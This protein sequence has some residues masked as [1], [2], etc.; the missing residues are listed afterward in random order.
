MNTGAIINS[1]VWSFREKETEAYKSYLSYPV[2]ELDMTHT[3]TPT[4]TSHF[5]QGIQVKKNQ[6]S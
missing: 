5:G 2:I 6:S 4:S 1:S 3:P